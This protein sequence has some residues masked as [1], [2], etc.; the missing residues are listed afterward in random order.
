MHLRH[1]ERAD[2]ETR[3]YTPWVEL[4]FKSI[5]I[6]PIVQIT[7]YYSL[8]RTI[9]HPLSGLCYYL[10]VNP[11]KMQDLTGETRGTFIKDDNMTFEKLS[12]LPYLNA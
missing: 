8:L 9:L 4:I 5:T 3:K 12:A 2:L 7:E 10:M 11:G 1:H 6:L